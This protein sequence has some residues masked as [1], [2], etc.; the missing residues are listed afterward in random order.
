MFNVDVAVNKSLPN[1]K[2]KLP[3]PFFN[4][5]VKILKKVL[6]EKTFPDI[7]KNNHH[8]SGLDFV[9]SMLKNLRISYTV[10]PHELQNIP[11]TGKLLVIANHVTGASDALSLTQVIASRRENRKVKLLVNGMLMGI[12]QI[13]P[14]MVPVDN[15]NGAITKKSLQEVDRLLENDEVIII[16]P[17][18]VVN[19]LS[20][21]GLKDS[22]WKA[23]F[24]KIARRSNTPILPIR[25]EGRNSLLFYQLVAL[26]PT[27]MAGLLLPREFAL[28]GKREALHLNIGKVIPLESFSNKNIDNYEY[29]DMFYAHL[30]NIGTDKQKVLKT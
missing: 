7:Y 12:E 10:K 13:A 4:L 23:S 27:K 11:A 6:H 17:T 22:T 21:H 29:I 3:K 14:I 20:I 5:F 30:Y 9:D 26:L 19:R 15:I 25:I 28:A 8:L 16:F 1:L 2:K 18:G 24:L